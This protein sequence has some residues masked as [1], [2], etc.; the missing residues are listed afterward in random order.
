MASRLEEI[1]QISRALHGASTHA[2]DEVVK[3]LDAH[4]SRKIL[5]P[6]LSE[7][8]QEEEIIAKDLGIGP[9][10]KKTKDA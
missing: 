8:V 1:E 4:G 6:T 3:I 9:E 10:Q 7:A 2:L 5:K